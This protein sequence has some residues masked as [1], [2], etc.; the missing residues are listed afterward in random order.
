VNNLRGLVV[1][2]DGGD[3]LATA[4]D[5]VDGNIAFVFAEARKRATAALG[6]AGD[7]LDATVQIG[8]RQSPLQNLVDGLMRDNVI[9]AWD[10]ARAVGG[11]ERLPAD[12]VAA[13]TDAMAL[14]TPAMR[15]PGSYGPELPTSADADAQTR[16]LA[17][18]GRVP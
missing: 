8:P 4:G 10:L 16:L 12:L 17:L 13:A 5:P 9:H 11:D 7:D 3:F 14:V 18:S 1:A 15:R 6:L 2:L